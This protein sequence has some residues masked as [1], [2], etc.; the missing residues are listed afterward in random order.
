MNIACFLISYSLTSW[1]C[2]TLTTP[3]SLTTCLESI[4]NHAFV[5]SDFPVILTLEDHLTPKL[6]A[7]FAEVRL[8]FNHSLP[9]T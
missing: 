2:R 7:K 4:K 6:Q 8:I 5:K 9:M 1:K 3:V